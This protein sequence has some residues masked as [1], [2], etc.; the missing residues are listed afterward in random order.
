MIIIVTFLLT[1]AACTHIGIHE[2][3]NEE[4]LRVIITSM[5]DGSPWII[6]FDPEAQKISFFEYD[7]SPSSGD[8]IENQ[9]EKDFWLIVSVNAQSALRDFGTSQ[10]THGIH[11]FMNPDYFED[12][13]PR[14]GTFFERDGSVTVFDLHGNETI[15]DTVAEYYQEMHGVCY[16]TAARRRELL[17]EIMDYYWEEYGHC[18]ELFDEKINLEFEQRWND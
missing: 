2:N 17:Q 11:A 7:G 14:G 8:C 15:F 10:Q 13:N 3:Q 9:T 16:E 5:S 4:I 12:M 1:I 6:Q 18:L